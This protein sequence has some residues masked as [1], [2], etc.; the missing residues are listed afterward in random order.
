MKPTA[1]HSSSGVVRVHSAREAADVAR[2]HDPSGETLL[3]ESEIV[4]DEVSVES[5]V[6]D[7]RI[8][9]SETT[10]KL[11]T[12]NSDRFVEMGHHV[13]PTALS[14][15]LEA[16]VQD[17]NARVVGELGVRTAAT[18]AEFRLGDAG[19]VLMETAVRPGGDAVWLL[20]HL[21]T[22]VPLEST[23]CAA[24]LGEITEPVCAEAQRW[25]AQHYARA[26]PGH[27]VAVTWNGPPTTV[28][29]VAN[30][31]PWPRLSSLPADAEP[32]VRCVL[33][34]KPDGDPVPA[35]SKS[36]DR[37]CSVVVDAPTGRE[38]DAVRSRAEEY[39]VSSQ[40]VSHGE[41]DR[42]ASTNRGRNRS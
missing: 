5:V 33:R 25:A 24:A 14:E 30:A 15:E 39:L 37:V 22:G 7:R 35:L 26:T 36:G 19:P 41:E 42:C 31:A 27:E 2:S 34:H 40:P 38:L 29:S 18:H 1:G 23:L 32:Q 11:T 13:G 3:L 16:A 8:V 21:A 17:A 10:L 4:G 20:H 6:A 9:R 12:E 28:V